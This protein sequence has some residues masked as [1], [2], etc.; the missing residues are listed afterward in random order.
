MRTIKAE[1]KAADV[2]KPIVVTLSHPS[3]STLK[4]VSP[5]LGS[6]YLKG[7]LLFREVFKCGIGIQ[8][9]SR[10]DARQH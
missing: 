5:H 8:A 1:E 4:V 6:F 10:T 7:R 3:H 2:S 9:V